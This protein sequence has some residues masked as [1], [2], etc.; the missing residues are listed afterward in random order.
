MLSLSRILAAIFL[1]SSTASA[2][3]NIVLIYADDLGYGDLGCYG[4]T[5]VKTPNIDRL[6]SQGIRFTDA[7]SSSATCTPS[8]YALLTGEY[9]WRKKGTGVL[10]GDA[11]LIIE[12]GRPTL[13]SMLKGA[14]YATGVVGKWHLGLGA[15]N[16]DWNADIKPGP[17]EIGFDECFLIPAT[18]DRVPTVYVENHRVAGLDP[19]DPITVDYQDP[20]GT[21]PTG[22]D[23]PELLKQK[24]THGHD[25]TI[26]NGISR[27][28]YMS[29]GKSARWV[30]EDMADV[31]T[32]K[33]VDFI[34]RH[35][36]EPFF[37]YFSTHDVHVPRAPHPRFAGKSGCGSRGDVIEEFDWS[38][39]EVMKALDDR[40]LAENTLLI[41]TSDNGPIVDDG[42]DDGAI[43]ALGDH[44]PSGPLRGNKYSLYEA[45]TRVPFLV[46]WPGRAKA[47][48]TS[49]ALVCQIDL[50]VS[51]AA[52]VGVEPPTGAF[53]DA[54]HELAALL[55]ESDEGRE[56]LVEH[57]NGLA[58]RNGKW[59]YIPPAPN[60]N[61]KGGRA[62]PFDGP[63]PAAEIYDLTDDLGEQ[64]NLAPGHEELVQDLDGILK[65]IQGSDPLPPRR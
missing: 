65:G 46:R 55:G 49:D 1:L 35:K 47:G 22:R 21:D 38:V 5:C 45:G 4:A 17:L 42:Y 32:N 40:G 60:R 10:P 61:P 29:G 11:R 9:P 58:L 30:D 53:P 48:K 25:M 7:H 39:G 50:P 51:L 37:L 56:L 33:A 24:L 54:E 14:G 6:A 52:L 16:L 59:K 43:E 34:D 2:G 63:G 3:P 20:V 64:H 26:V 57:A 28:G 31:I 44:D 18:G 41:V 13:A 36:A 12:P 8:R 62:R 23:H 19:S 15:G 27:I